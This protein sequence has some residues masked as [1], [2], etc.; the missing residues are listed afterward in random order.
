MM[1]RKHNIL[2]LHKLFFLNSLW[3]FIKIVSTS[4]FTLLL[5]IT[6]LWTVPFYC[7]RHFWRFLTITHICFKITF[8]IGELFKRKSQERKHII[9]IWHLKLFGSYSETPHIFL[10]C[11][12]GTFMSFDMQIPDFSLHCLYV[13]EIVVN[14]YIHIMYKKNLKLNSKYF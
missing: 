13:N 11:F 8:E 3:S 7:F 9:R 14:I 2:P 1:S 5:S 10:H 4:F 6:K 12:L